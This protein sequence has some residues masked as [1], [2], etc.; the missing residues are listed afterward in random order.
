LTDYIDKDVLDAMT[1]QGPVILEIN[2][3]DLSACAAEVAIIPD[4]L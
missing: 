2:S 4:N 3:T 1:I